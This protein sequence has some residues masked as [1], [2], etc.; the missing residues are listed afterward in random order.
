MQVRYKKIE[1]ETTINY[2]REEDIV[3]IAT[4]IMK[5]KNKL[6]RYGYEPDSEEDGL[7]IF[8][9]PKNEFTWGRRRKVSEK[10]RRSA[11]ER[12]KRYNEERRIRA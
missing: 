9:I 2:N 3:N 8:N 7:F 4:S 5:D 6:S 1:Q 10:R 12:M 11:S